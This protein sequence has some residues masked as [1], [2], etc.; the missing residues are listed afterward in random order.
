MLTPYSTVRLVLPVASSPPRHHH[1]HQ[2]L[3]VRAVDG[4]FPCSVWTHCTPT[5]RPLH[6]LN[7]AATNHTTIETRKRLAASNHP[8]RY[9]SIPCGWD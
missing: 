1:H 2:P 4:A 8:D 3:L 5:G 7:C 9:G 6:N